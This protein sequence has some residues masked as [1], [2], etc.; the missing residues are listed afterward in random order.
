[1]NTRE[2]QAINKLQDNTQVIREFE[3]KD[4]NNDERISLL[5]LEQLF[6]GL[7]DNYDVNL[8][9]KEADVDD[10]SHIDFREFVRINLKNYN[11][12]YIIIKT[13]TFMVKFK[14]IK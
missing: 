9:M 11:W 13:K 5:E 3:I 12:T 2:A 14:I 7:D 4:R 6:K 1:M 10:N 8:I